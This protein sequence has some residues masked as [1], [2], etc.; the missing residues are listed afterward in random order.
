MRGLRLAL[1]LAGL[2][3]F[4]G[5]AGASAAPFAYVANSLSN[6]VSV[7]DI[8]TNS[9]VATVAVGRYSQ[10]VAVTPDGTHVYVTNTGDNTVSVIER[11]TNAVGTTVPAVVSTVPVG[12]TR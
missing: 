8:A 4:A 9:V 5:A 12:V 7:L 1:W 11:A 10:G 3:V 6:N 2:V